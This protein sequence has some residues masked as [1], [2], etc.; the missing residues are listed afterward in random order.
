MA[1]QPSSNWLALHAMLAQGRPAG[2]PVSHDGR[3]YVDW[4]EF[5][6][7]AAGL[8]RVL[9]AR[10]EVRWLLTS[11]DPL[12]FAV[13]LFALFHAGKQAVV[14]PNAREGTLA[15]LAAAFDARVD[16]LAAAPAPGRLEAFDPRAAIID[17]YTSGSTG[18]NKRVRKT[19][20]QFEAEVAVLETLWGEK[21][22]ASVLVATAPHRH[23]YGLLFRLFWPLASG[24]V[25]DAVT[26]ADPGTLRAR[27][28]LFGEAALVS[29]PA[30]LTRL[31]EWLPL[32]ELRPRPAAIFSSGAPLPAAAALALKDGLGE[33]PIEIFGSTE[34]GGVAWRQQDGGDGDLWT[35]FPCHGVGRSPGGA[36]TL[37]SPFLDSADALEMDDGIELR[38]DGRFRLLGRLDRVVKI[39]EKRLSLPEMEARLAQHPWVEAAAVT[40]LAGRRQILGAALV[41]NETGRERLQRHGRRAVA[42]D[43]RGHLAGHFD[44]V[45]LPR[46]WRFPD[47]LPVDERGKLTA[48]AL[49]ALFVEEPG[50]EKG[51]G[52]EAGKGEGGR[53][54]GEIRGTKNQ[55]SVERPPVVTRPPSPFPLPGP[56]DS[57]LLPTVLRAESDGLRRARIELRVGAEIA[58]FAGHFPGAPILPGI[59]QVDWAI[60]FAREHLPL[61]GAFSALENLKFLALVRPGDALLLTLD[62]DPEARRLDFSYTRAGRKTAAGRALLGGEP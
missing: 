3:R 6:A 9:R 51:D 34:T 42:G 56:N 19:L 57:N 60:R 37:V 31:P 20:A 53:E 23:I 55:C 15:S 22:G 50:R 58:H 14:P 26:C 17:L 10:P 62:W 59:V 61:R 11:D 29:S 27:L 41:L 54:K 47:R 33:A 8:A 40:T 44:A 7:R 38:A 18:E 12:D 2:R 5:S 16:A 25:F 1:A 45:L 21:I 13:E 36:L 52:E 24:R 49:A 32:A 39:E 4:K 35:P 43:L 30:Q 48:A 28:A 46:R